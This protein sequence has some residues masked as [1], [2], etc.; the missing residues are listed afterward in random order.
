MDLEKT[1]ACKTA[2]VAAV[3]IVV[4][5]AAAVAIIGPESALLINGRRHLH[6]D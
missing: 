6:C 3:T 2:I 1:K 4:A 5:V